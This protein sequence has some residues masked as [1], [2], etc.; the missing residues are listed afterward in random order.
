MMDHCPLRPSGNHCILP[1]EDRRRSILV[2]SCAPSHGN[3][4]QFCPLILPTVAAPP[5]C[6]QQRGG[7]V[8][9]ANPYSRLTWLTTPRI[10]VGSHSRRKWYP[11]CA[12]SNKIFG[13]M[14]SMEI[15][16][17][18]CLRD[19]PQLWSREVRT[20][21]ESLPKLAEKRSDSLNRARA[22]VCS[23]FL[24]ALPPSTTKRIVHIAYGGK[25]SG[26]GSLRP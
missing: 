24:P 11:A 10:T 23:A 26:C 22:T 13:Q 7:P 16:E 2:S 14:A 3:I 15:A 20:V 21:L 12:V 6:E 8:C 9:D 19:S 5:F 18:Q 4:A 17:S 1:G 25:R